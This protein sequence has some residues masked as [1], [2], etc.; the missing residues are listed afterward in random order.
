[1]QSALNTFFVVKLISSARD[2]SAT[3]TEIN[4]FFGQDILGVD[5]LVGASVGGGDKTPS[6][7]SCSCWKICVLAMD[8]KV[9]L[10][11]LQGHG[12]SSKQMH[13]E[14]FGCL[15]TAKRKQIQ[16]RKHEKFCFAATFSRA[17]LFS[18]PCW[19]TGSTLL[20]RC[21]RSLSHQLVNRVL[22]LRLKNLV[23]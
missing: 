12:Q 16:R 22:S 14:N 9:I 23:I 8:N 1:M 19:A 4:I 7:S 20:Q 3:T 5:L 11:G 10:N 2:S 18:I 21:C 13:N 15:E 17:G 6:P